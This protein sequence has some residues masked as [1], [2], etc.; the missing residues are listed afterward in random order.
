MQADLFE[1]EADHSHDIELKK[2]NDFLHLRLQQLSKE[3]EKLARYRDQ[4]GVFK[5]KLEYYE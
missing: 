3:N 1:D 2:E 4:E 5:E